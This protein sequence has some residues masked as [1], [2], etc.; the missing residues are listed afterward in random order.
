MIYINLILISTR[1]DNT[2]MSGGRLTRQRGSVATLTIPDDHLNRRV[3]LTGY[4][5]I[6]LDHSNPDSLKG[7]TDDMNRIK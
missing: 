4:T 1:I 6:V 5:N 2:R 7:S 3:S